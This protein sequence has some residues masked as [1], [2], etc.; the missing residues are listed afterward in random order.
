MNDRKSPLGYM[1]QVQQNTMI[2]LNN[3]NMINADGSTPVKRTLKAKN[4]ASSP[5]PSPRS[6]AALREA[7]AELVEG[8]QPTTHDERVKGHLAKHFAPKKAK[9]DPLS[10]RGKGADDV[11][12][13]RLVYQLLDREG[14]GW[15]RKW[16]GKK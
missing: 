13:K 8:V 1:T 3:N 4:K 15:G 9:V 6:H 2:N 12:L 7:S 10:T 16:I 11:E 14:H 5:P